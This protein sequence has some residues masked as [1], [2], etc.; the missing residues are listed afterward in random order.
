MRSRAVRSRSEISICNVD[1][2]PEVYDDLRDTAQAI[3]RNVY[4]LRVNV[5]L[6][7]ACKVGTQKGTTRR[8]IAAI[9]KLYEEHLEANR[10][11]IFD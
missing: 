6:L 1:I 4:G 7:S 5:M 10:S 2:M 11:T 3:A 9:R 8:A